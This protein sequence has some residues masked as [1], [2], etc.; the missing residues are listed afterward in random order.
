ML[1]GSRKVVA[2]LLS[3]CGLALAACG[4][5]GSYAGNWK[6]DLYSEGE[7]RM[8]IGRDGT[9]ALML[10]APRWPDSVDYKSKAAFKGDTLVFPADTS[11]AACQNGEAKY[12][13]NK[14]GEGLAVAG[15]GF[16]PCGGRH[17]GL[18]G[19]WTKG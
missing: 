1:V 7:V 12:V 18:V 8:E 19:A 10:P 11:A 17:A 3:V 9:V 14:S 5:S 2:G 6:R 15:I 16:D 4:G 13:L